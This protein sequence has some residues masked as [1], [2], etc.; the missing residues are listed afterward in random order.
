MNALELLVTFLPAETRVIRRTG[1]EMSCRHYWAPEL[2]DL[3][4]HGESALVYYDPRDITHVYFRAANGVLIEAKATEKDTPRISLNE[5]NRWRRKKREMSTSPA[6]LAQR[7]AGL[8]ATEAM[9]DQ[10]VRKTKAAKRKAGRAKSSADAST[11][12]PEADATE[13]D[14]SGI[15]F[16]RAIQKL[17]VLEEVE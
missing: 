3:L 2:A 16:T 17:E 6:L 14:I 9:V 15:D 7:D 10:A 13:A 12:V 4:D 5:W 11:A 1:I 8:L